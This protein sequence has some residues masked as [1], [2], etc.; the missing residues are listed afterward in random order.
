MSLNNERVAGWVSIGSE[1]FNSQNNRLQFLEGWKCLLLS[2]IR[3][4]SLS[5]GDAV[6]SHSG[7][8]GIIIIIIIIIIIAKR[9]LLLFWGEKAEFPSG[10]AVALRC[11]V[12]EQQQNQGWAGQRQGG[13]QRAGCAGGN[14]AGALRK[15][16]C[17]VPLGREGGR[18]GAAETSH[19]QNVGQ[20]TQTSPGQQ[21]AREVLSSGFI[22][23]FP[24]NKTP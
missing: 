13:L 9:C 12:Y 23:V 21:R 10:S 7:A 22:T 4:L 2:E 3:R 17:Q 8:E 18:K 24:T 1:Q 14:A 16:G 11:S 19:P 6:A 20:T 15:E 5:P